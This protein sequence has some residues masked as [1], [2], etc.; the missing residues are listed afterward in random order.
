MKKLFAIAAL[1]LVLILVLQLVSLACEP[2]GA[3][4][5]PGFWKNHTEVWPVQYSQDLMNKLKARGH[6]SNILRHE[7]ADMLNSLS[8]VDYCAGD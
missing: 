3:T 8:P 5:S 2:T 7:V 4:C 1:V 6:G